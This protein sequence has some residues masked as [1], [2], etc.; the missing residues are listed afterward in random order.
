M[1]D[2]KLIADFMGVQ[3]KSDEDYFKELAEMREDG[4]FY[5]QGYM[6]SQ[7]N[8]ESWGWLMPVVEKIEEQHGCDF[9]A[10]K[11]RATRTYDANFMDEMNNDVVYVEDCKDRKEATYKAVVEFIK[12]CVPL[13]KE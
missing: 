5:E 12:N 9:I 11:R 4:I 1:K 10:T 2:N 7:L 6:E 13:E 3:Y 8:Y